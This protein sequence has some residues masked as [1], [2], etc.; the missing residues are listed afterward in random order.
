MDPK[1]YAK[2]EKARHT[3]GGDHSYAKRSEPMPYKEW[4]R[5]E[6]DWNL[7]IDF[8]KDESL[9][10]PEIIFNQTTDDYKEMKP[11]KQKI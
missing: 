2:K 10:P 7:A 11:K 1:G 9:R 8:V 5:R 3:A 6:S 4:A